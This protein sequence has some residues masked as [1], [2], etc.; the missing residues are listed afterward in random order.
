MRR[1]GQFLVRR[2]KALLIWAAS[3]FVVFTLVG[4]FVVPLIVKSVL[5]N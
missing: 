5:T 3:L 1:F 2:R 4:F